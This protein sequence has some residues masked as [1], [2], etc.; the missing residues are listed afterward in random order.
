MTSKTKI[1]SYYSTVHC[2]AYEE[3]RIK[4]PVLQQPYPQQENRI[5]SLLFDNRDIDRTKTTL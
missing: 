2:P 1:I 3:E 4:N 5:G